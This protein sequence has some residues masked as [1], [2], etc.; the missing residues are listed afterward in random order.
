[1]EEEAREGRRFTVPCRSAGTPGNLAFRTLRGRTLV[2]ADG[3]EGESMGDAVG[4]AVGVEAAE[5]WWALGEGL[6]PSSESLP[7][8]T[9]G[10]LEDVTDVSEL[11]RGLVDGLA[12]LRRID[13]G[14]CC[15]CCCCC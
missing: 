3:R 6:T 9:P 4:D 14:C 15:C 2:E 1:M 7:A 10:M 12:D 8:P 13:L 5:M 11:R